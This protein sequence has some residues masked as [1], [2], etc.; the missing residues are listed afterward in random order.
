MLKW[1]WITTNNTGSGQCRYGCSQGTWQLVR[2]SP[3]TRVS[4]IRIR[5][6]VCSFESWAGAS[7]SG[8]TAHM[9]HRFLANKKPQLMPTLH[10]RF[11]A[12]RL[13]QS[14]VEGTHTGRRLYLQF[15][16]KV[17]CRHSSDRGRAAFP[18]RRC[19]LTIMDLGWGSFGGFRS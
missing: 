19:T 14:L 10:S 18:S 13:G 3:G 7:E 2:V 8:F 9:W 16:A 17:G 4:G 1:H 6:L 12:R 11:S 15:F 5:W